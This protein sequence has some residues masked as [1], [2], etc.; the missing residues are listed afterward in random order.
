MIR[1]PP[2]STRTDTL[3]PYTTLFRSALA[4]H[5][6]DELV[7]K[8]IVP[9]QG[10]EGNMEAAFLQIQAMGNGAWMTGQHLDLAGIPKLLQPLKFLG[11]PLV[12]E[13][14]VWE[15]GLADRKSTRL[16]SSH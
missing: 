4:K 9:G 16:T 10:I 14:A 8:L 6:A 2:R 12:D 13:D 15:A 7:I 11:R 1:Q 5:P 3:L